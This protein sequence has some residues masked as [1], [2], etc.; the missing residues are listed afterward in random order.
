M[1]TDA[2]WSDINADGAPDLIVAGE[3]MPIR[4]FLNRDGVFEEQTEAIDAP[5]RGWWYSL[6]AADLDG[7]GDQDLVAGNLGLNHTYTASPESPFGVVAADLTG[8][9]T[10][11]IILTKTVDETEYPLYGLA[12]LGRDIYT[13]GIRYGSFAE[14]AEASVEQVAGREAMEQALHYHTDTFASVWLENDGQGAFTMH[15]LPNLAQ[16]AP[17]MDIVVED[18]DGDGHPDLIIAG[19]LYQSEP[20]APR[21]DAGKGLWLRGDGKGGFTPV[22]PTQSGLLAPGDVKELRLVQTVK[23]SLLLV[24]TENEKL[25]QFTI[26][27]ADK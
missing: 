10:T 13:V 14:F 26:N 8:N 15:R 24:G 25:Q 18:A 7:D 17:V 4:V 9:R 5:S 22:S 12:K 23:S 16:I 3:W 2:R 21:A 1:V 6:Q 11:D 19:N 20:T 27:N